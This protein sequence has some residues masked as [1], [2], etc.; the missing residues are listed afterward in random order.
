MLH[1]VTLSGQY[2]TL[3]TTSPLQQDSYSDCLIFTEIRR[4][5]ETGRQ[6]R[7]EYSACVCLRRGRR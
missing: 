6:Y 4:E 2:S 5:C 7:Y 3:T 1:C